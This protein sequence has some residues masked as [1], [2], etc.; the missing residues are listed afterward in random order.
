MR[1]KSRKLMSIVLSLAV[2]LSVGL[3]MLMSMGAANSE[4]SKA[5]A[6]EA[7]AETLNSIGLFRGTNPDPNNPE[8][9]L[10]RTP[11]R[12]EG[13]VMLIRLMGAEDEALSGDYDCPF[14]DVPEWAA[15]YA[16][17]AYAMGWTKGISENPPLYGPT[18]S[19]TATQYLTFVL[20]ALGYV[21]G[22][23]F[24]WNAA[25]VL[26]DKLGIT[27]GEYNAGHNTLVR[28]EMAI[29]SLVAL[30]TPLKGS[31]QT[32]LG[33][34]VEDGVFEKLAEEGLIKDKDLLEAI[35]TGDLEAI[36]EAIE[37]LV[38][39]AVEKVE[40]LLAGTAEEAA[41]STPSSSSAAP[42]TTPPPTT[43][44]G[45]S[46]SGSSGIVPDGAYWYIAA[47]PSSLTGLP[48][49]VL[50]DLKMDGFIFKDNSNIYVVKTATASSINTYTVA[51]NTATA[52]WLNALHAGV[53][54][55]TL[56]NDSY[57]ADDIVIK[58][59]NPYEVRLW[60]NG[61]SA[62]R[63]KYDFMGSGLNK[64]NLIAVWSDYADVSINSVSYLDIYGDYNK[65]SASEVYAFYVEGDNNMLTF[66][67]YNDNYWWNE[68]NGNYLNGDPLA[69]KAYPKP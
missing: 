64:L 25:W 45:G 7:A 52:A 18:A 15:G 6:E 37:E 57:N 13:L 68:G 4:A 56:E 41:T 23:D 30:T 5:D 40:A 38:A 61:T 14:G 27:D 36:L 59:G 42:P 33:K 51:N 11:N 50:N 60:R 53:P 48:F 21:D 32:L 55:P 16:G 47:T 26:T 10:D 67:N 8:F 2:L 46:G 24:E 62:N 1:N 49:D 22:V 31:E 65:I 35:A 17:Y 34:L 44:P 66:D 28:G 58:G 9:Q 20:R 3:G 63:V 54:T 69:K 19:I 29:I 39:E 12:I 43:N